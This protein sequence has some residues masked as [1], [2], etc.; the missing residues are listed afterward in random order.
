MHLEGSHQIHHLTKKAKL[1]S[2]PALKNLIKALRAGHDGT[3]SNPALQRLRQED[4]KFGANLSSIASSRMVHS[5]VR[6]C[7]GRE[8]KSIPGSHILKS[9]N[10]FSSALRPD[11]LDPPWV[12]FLGHVWEEK[13]IQASQQGQQLRFLVFPV[14]CAGPVSFPL[15]KVAQSVLVSFIDLATYIFSVYCVGSQ[16]RCL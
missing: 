12:G 8:G 15:C 5:I 11:D 10:D 16:G 9:S 13:Q 3:Q 2:V 1:R 6:P 14:L 4:C 7:S